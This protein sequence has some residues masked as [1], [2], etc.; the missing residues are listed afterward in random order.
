M[1]EVNTSTAKEEDE[2]LKREDP[3]MDQNPVK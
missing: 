2:E 1:P 3:G